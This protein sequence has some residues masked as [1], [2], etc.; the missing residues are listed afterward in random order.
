MKK[1]YVIEF[2]KNIQ[3]FI[4]GQ[5]SM[6]KEEEMLEHLLTCKECNEE[7]EIYYTIINCI[8]ELDGKLETS[9][10]YHGEYNDFIEKTRREIRKYKKNRFRRRIAFP[11]VVGA[12]V[13]FT[14]LSVNME[15]QNNVRENN[16]SRTFIDNDLSMR[17]RFN[18]SHILSDPY[19]NI[20]ELAKEIESRRNLHE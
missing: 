9:D 14:G 7:L 8:K 12:A 4:Y 2:Q 10:N 6:L 1:L 3:P 15:V 11:G 18:D 16:E 19:S 20:D 17:F 13:L 5:L